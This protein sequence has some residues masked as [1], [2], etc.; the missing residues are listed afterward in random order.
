MCACARPFIQ[1]IDIEATSKSRGHALAGRRRRQSLISPFL[2]SRSVEFKRHPYDPD[3]AKKLLAE[4]GY[5]NGFTVMIDCSNDRDVNDEAICPASM[6]R[7]ARIGVLQG[8][9]VGEW[10]AEDLGKAGTMKKTTCCF[11]LAGLDP[12]LFREPQR[13]GQY[14]WLLCMR[15]ARA[16]PSTTAA[17][18]IPEGGCDLA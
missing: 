2:N 10:K 5:P 14:C 9:A 12:G 15:T 17:T 18:A 7:L 16:A 1:A 3:A 4:A 11:N 13:A 8:G 6:T